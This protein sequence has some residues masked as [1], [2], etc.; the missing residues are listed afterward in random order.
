MNSVLLVDGD[1]DSLS[2]LQHSLGNRFGLIEHATDTAT[3]TA[4]LERCHFDLLISD[5]HL[6]DCS[7][8]AWTRTLRERGLLPTLIFLCADTGIHSAIE[9][10]RTGAADF[11]LKPFTPEQV[12]NAVERCLEHGDPG[13]SPTTGLENRHKAQATGSDALVGESDAMRHISQI[14]RQVASMPSTVL[15][16]GES[17]TGK[18]LVARAIHHYSG[19]KGHFVSINCGALPAELLES[20]LFGHVRGAFTSA[21]QTRDGLFAHASGGTLLLDE[22]GEMP[23]EMQVHLLRVLETRSIRPLGANQEI[24]VD[25]RILTATN[26]QLQQEVERGRF[27]RDLFYRLNVL[28]LRLP[29]LRERGDDLTLLARYFVARLSRQFGLSPCRLDEAELA[30]LMAYPWP[31][32]VRELRNVLERALLLKLPPSQCLTTGVP[33]AAARPATVTPATTTAPPVPEPATRGLGDTEHAEAGGDEDAEALRLETV[34]KRH[35]LAMLK[36][37][38]GNKSAAARVLGISRKTLERK[39]VR[40]ERATSATGA[41][42]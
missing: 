19:R 30:R 38:G 10:L 12:R 28:S 24:P 11:I 37:A 39:L 18:E 5:I 9:A 6:P 17:G 31:G 36:R 23:L 32:N 26:R 20:E 8:P 4:L 16:E 15:L 35:I 34:E 33:P 29:P 3:A 27:R 21:H 1:P 42:S 40:W 7:G 14:I 2:L 41:E 13:R 22:I 25:V